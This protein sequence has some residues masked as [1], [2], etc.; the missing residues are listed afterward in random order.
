MIHRLRFAFAFLLVM[1][2]PTLA[3]AEFREM[4]LAVRGMD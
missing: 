2:L 4:Q 1:A 3:S